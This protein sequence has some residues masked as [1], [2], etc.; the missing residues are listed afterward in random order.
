MKKH[1]GTTLQNG[2]FKNYYNVT[3]III[4]DLNTG[5]IYTRINAVEL[6]NIVMNENVKKWIFAIYIINLFLYVLHPL[7][8]LI[9]TG[10]VGLVYGDYYLLMAIGLIFLEANTANVFGLSCGFVM[11]LFYIIRQIVL[12][13]VI[14]KK[15]NIKI[16][17][18]I[19]IL[20]FLFM[21]GMINAIFSE[22]Y[23]FTK[24]I[25]FIKDNLIKLVII[26]FSI[27]MI[28]D[29]SHRTAKQ[30]E[31]LVR[32]LI[33]SIITA[34][35]VSGI[36]YL[37][38][39]NQGEVRI[40]MD[41]HKPG[42]Y[43]ILLSFSIIAIGYYLKCYSTKI[44]H[45]LLLAGASLFILYI[46]LVS[47]S[48]IG[49]ITYSL[50]VFYYFLILNKDK[51]TKIVFFTLLIT[52]AIIVMT[53]DLPMFTALHIR[54][55]T[56]IINGE[57]MSLSP[58]RFKMWMSFPKII[59]NNIYNF[60]FG[61]GA[62]NTIEISVIKEYIG[63]DKVAHNIFLTNLIQLG[64]FGLTVF[65][66]ILYR[67]LKGLRS[68]VLINQVL[69][70]A[71]LIAMVGGIIQPIVY[72]EGF[73]FVL[74][75]AIGYNYGKGKK[76]EKPKVLHLIPHFD[77]GG[78]EIQVNNMAKYMNRVQMHVGS[79]LRG[80]RY[81]EMTKRLESNG[82][83]HMTL[84]KPKK[85]K[86][87]QGIIKLSR[88]IEREEIDFIHTHCKSPDFYGITAAILNNRRAFITIHNTE[89]Y[90]RIVQ[91]IYC[92]VVD[93]F[94]AIS[95]SVKTYMNKE[96]KLPDQKIITINNGIDLEHFSNV[97]IDIEEK[98]KA[99]GLS[100]KYLIVTVGRVSEQKNH[101]LM[102]KAAEILK[103]QSIDVK[104]LIVGRYEEDDEYY[105]ELVKLIHEK[106]LEDIILFIGQRDDI[107]EILKMADVFIL[108]SLYEGMSLALM[109]A[110]ASRTP[111]VCTNTGTASELIVDGVS[112]FF[113]DSK[114]AIQMAEKIKVVLEDANYANQLANHAYSELKDVYDIK[115]VAYQYEELYGVSK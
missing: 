15:I 17:A 100:S 47:G 51:K 83:R 104:M 14:D 111:V 75:L 66:F 105:Q 49:L 45:K 89:G 94:I 60:I 91:W 43:T 26:V 78:S 77:I 42:K 76:H 24:T 35:V 68:E 115:T 4:I 90:N 57:W 71:A 70:V 33:I 101:R 41:I 97:K 32:P 102:I 59:F 1:Y 30:R 10:I 29:I 27:M 81:D 80:S 37:I 58:A 106:D 109:E 8:G 74:S 56:P 16:V 79:V 34:S 25:F 3:G 53:S 87:L 39:G 23:D 50:A 19:L 85:E 13:I 84:D 2:Y 52:G 62:S 107:V 28:L 18:P 20:I 73:W 22:Y 44:Y 98:R 6:E 96:L 48:R 69:S 86:R 88:Y 65:G 64:L 99:F 95:D 92:G 36:L 55:I 113:H 40:M 93:K 114:N 108:P 54:V 112:G 110:I 11:Y 61:Y 63:V 21:T 12:M 72:K 67:A 5:N 9:M 82:I 46:I 38:Q 7:A 31:D 103:Q